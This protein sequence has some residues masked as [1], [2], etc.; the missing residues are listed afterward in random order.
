MARVLHLFSRHTH[1]LPLLRPPAAPPLP[2]IIL[3]LHSICMTSLNLAHPVSCAAST[4]LPP[5]WIPLSPR[6]KH[7]YTS[8]P[9]LNTYAIVP[10]GPNFLKTLG[11]P[12][13]RDR[14]F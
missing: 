9:A 11:E 14:T 13:D 2:M 10:A 12:H 6:Q 3:Q 4:P 8:H 7:Y 5:E 1:F